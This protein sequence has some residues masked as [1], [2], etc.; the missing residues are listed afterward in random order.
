[1]PG[2]PA[3][4]AD[5][6]RPPAPSNAYERS[7][8]TAELVALTFANSGLPVVI[9]RPE[10]IYGPGD[11]H[12][13]GLYRAIKRGLFFYVGNGRSVCHPT[14]IDDAVS[15][16]LG[17]LRHG[18]P[19]QIYHIAGPEPVTFEQLAQ[20]IAR[21]LAVRPP[22]LRLP[23]P[24]AWLGAA[25]LE[26]LAK[27]AGF[28]PPLSRTGVAFFSESRHFDWQKAHQEFGYRPTYDLADG[29]AAT[30]AW[31]RAQGLLR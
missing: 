14:Y 31:Y 29:V 12:V 28:T 22:W 5:E 13:L 24:L 15:G 27:V 8:A 23:R 3:P 20:T 17:A 4:P 30:V 7:K 9:G 19:G 16:L 11:I 6:N 18:R 26:L 10:F 21:A 2:P 25:L 1:M